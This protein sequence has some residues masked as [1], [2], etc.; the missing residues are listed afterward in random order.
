M[1]LFNYTTKKHVLNFNFKSLLAI[2]FVLFFAAINSFAN[3]KVFKELT[4]QIISYDKCN[5]DY[6]PVANAFDNDINTYFRSCAPFGNWIG[7]DL[8]EKCVITGLAYCPRVDSDYRDRLQLGV[9]EGA[10]NPDFGDAVTLFVIPGLVERQLTTQE[11]FCTRAFRY[12]RFVFPYAQ[13]DGKSSYMSELKFYGYAD[14]GNDTHFPQI[15]NLPTISIHTVAAQDIT[16]KEEYI[17]GIVSVVYDNGTKFFTDSLKIKG[18]G[19][20]SWTHPKKP[21]KMKL[22]HSA[23]LLDLPAKAKEWTLINSYGDKT[24][25]RNMLAF[26]FSRRL[27]MPYTSPAEAVD[28]V[29]NGDY[30]GCY[31][32]CDQIEVRTDRVETD[33]FDS[34]T[35]DTGYMIEIDAYAYLENKKF[36]SQTY[37]IPVSIKYPDED[38]IKTEH[39]TYINNQFEKFVSSV[40]ASDY[41]NPTTGFRKYLDVETFLRHFLVGE[42]SGNTDT[43]WSVKMSKKKSD[44][45]FYFGPVWDF[46]LGFENDHRTYSITDKALTY[47]EWIALWTETSAAGGTKNMIRRILSDDGMITRLKEIYSGYRDSQAISRESLENVIDSCATLLAL[48]QDLNFKRWPIMNTLVHENPVIYG[49]YE[50]EVDNVREYVSNRISW[51]DNKL[52]YIPAALKQITSSGNYSVKIFSSGGVLHVSELPTGSIIKVL[53]LYGRLLCEQQNVTE[54]SLPLEKGVYVISIKKGSQTDIYKYTVY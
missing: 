43:Y 6:F 22:Y 8:G 27:Q 2:V 26:D 29:L 21:Y 28:V 54:L 36:T 30:K 20:N 10:N 31:Q 7:L 47:N 44:D 32:L 12:V 4:G 16:S 11:I 3:T 42:Y 53:D 15:T 39:E 35:V 24:L 40:N 19:N 9:F 25:M 52:N 34:T 49:S 1:S 13:T 50:G 14:E 17:N 18:R 37:G 45:H 46:D 5:D 38:V 51:L 41:K 23:H 48:S 33:E